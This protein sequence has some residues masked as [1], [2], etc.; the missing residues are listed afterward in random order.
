[1]VDQFF[2]ALSKRQAMLLLTSLAFGGSGA[3]EAYAHLEPAEEELLRHRAQALIQV[4]REKR[5]PLLVKE[6]KRLVAHRRRHLVG[7]DP[8]RIAQILKAER[9]MVIEVV[10][11]A[12]SSDLALAVRAALGNPSPT[13]LQRDVKPEVLSLVRWKLEDALRAGLPH[14]GS[15]RFTDIMV[16]PS[17]EI[18]ALVD[19]MGARVLATAVAGLGVDERERLLGKLTPDQRVLAARAAEVGAERRLSEA[20]ANLAFEIHGGLNQ[21]SLCLHSAGAQRL[22]RACY[23]QSADFAARFASR[24]QDELGAVLSRWLRDEKRRPVKGDGGRRDIVEQLERLAQKGVIDRPMRLP[25]PA[26]ATALVAN[27]S[28]PSAAIRR[29]SSPLQPIPRRKQASGRS[30]ESTEAPS[31]P[32]RGGPSGRSR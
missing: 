18:L 26:K 25:P 30:E 21:P 4:P 19:R 23:A 24:H 12:L 13:K 6:M 29:N 10:L 28:A 32:K 14:V 17:R 9:P 16:M 20:D 27:N 1:M 5:V 15:F 8:K 7:A 11:G 22:I 2:S 3:I 31:P